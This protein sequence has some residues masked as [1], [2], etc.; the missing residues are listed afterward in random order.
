MLLFKCT[1][2]KRIVRMFL[3]NFNTF[4]LV[5][6]LL[7]WAQ[8]YKEPVFELTVVVKNQD[9]DPVEDV[10]IKIVA[11]DID[12]EDLSQI[13]G[14]NL[15]DIDGEELVCKTDGSGACQFSFENKAFLTILACFNGDSGD[16]MCAEAFIYLEEDE[17]HTRELLLVDSDK[18]EYGC[19]YCDD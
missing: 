18:N 10:S 16:P 6:M 17:S 5:F 14:A 15:L 8:C 9:L 7:F 4:L 12:S 3:K 19:E 13:P 1:L 2:Y 11:A